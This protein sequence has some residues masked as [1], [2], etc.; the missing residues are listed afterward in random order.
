MVRFLAGLALGIALGAGGM[1]LANRPPEAP[2]ATSQPVVTT[3]P[4]V[5][6]KGKK[7]GK[8]KGNNGS[9]TSPGDEAAPDTEGEPDE[10][11]PVLS[12]ADLAPSAQGDTLSPRPQSLD[13]DRDSEAH[14][15]GEGEINA[16][17]RGSSSSL[18][19]CI[20]EA[21]GAAQL[22]GDV[23]FGVVI[24]P[25]GRVVKSRVEAP[26]Y[27]LRQGLAGCAR[28]VLATLRFPAPGRD[29]VASKSYSLR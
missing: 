21:R 13:F 20:N 5:P 7:K 8:K 6:E 29:V 10:P 16:V 17:F 9:P 15:L 26:S 4:S 23:K 27:L 18:T 24:G 2:P 19:A 1:Y 25:D 28:P 22:S 14:E 11:V 12:A 3:P